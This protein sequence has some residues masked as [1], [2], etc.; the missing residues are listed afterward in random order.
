MAGPDYS[1]LAEYTKEYNEVSATL[2][3]K[4]LRWEELA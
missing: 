3:E 1:K 4:Y 2:D